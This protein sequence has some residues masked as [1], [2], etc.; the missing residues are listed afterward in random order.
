[1][2]LYPKAISGRARIQG[3]GSGYSGVTDREAFLVRYTHSP[4]AISAT[5]THANITLP[6]TGTTVV[7]TGITQPDVPRNLTIKG[8][9]SGIAGNVVIAGKRGGKAITETIALNGATEVVGTKAF[10]HVDSI[11]VPAKTNASGDAV[12]IGVGNKLGLQHLLDHNTVQAA[13]LNKVKEGTPPTVAV[14]ATVLES[15]LVTLSSA[16]DGNRVDIYY[17]AG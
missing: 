13:Y 2:G 1:M 16:L 11:T 15:N 10:D 4:V 14:S 3:G 6:A 8:N 7:T 12:S 9:A 5:R 17:W